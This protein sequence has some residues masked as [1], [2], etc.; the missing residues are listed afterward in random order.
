MRGF[1]AGR[2]DGVPPAASFG[3]EISGSLVTVALMKAH[4]GFG[5]STL[6]N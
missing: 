1:S 4:S 6:L 5:A 3:L 2:A